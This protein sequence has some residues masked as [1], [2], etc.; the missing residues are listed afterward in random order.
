MFYFYF[1]FCFAFSEPIS[2]GDKLFSDDVAAKIKSP[3]AGSKSKKSKKKKE[4][5]QLDWLVEG[6]G[7]IADGEDLTRTRAASSEGKR[8]K[9]HKGIRALARNSNS[10]P[11]KVPK[12]R[13]PGFFKI[14][15][16][17]FM[18]CLSVW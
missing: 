18:P 17:F 9:L 5:S 1:C 15:S 7:D 11:G 3:K 16:V 13:K 14:H 6:G 4:K 2:P 10:Y 8:K 12:T